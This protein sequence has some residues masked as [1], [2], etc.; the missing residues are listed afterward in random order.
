MTSCPGI[1]LCGAINEGRVPQGKRMQLRVVFDG[2]ASLSGNTGKTSADGIAVDRSRVEDI[3]GGGLSAS[4]WA[5][6]SCATGGAGGRGRGDS[7]GRDT[8]PDASFPPR[9][10]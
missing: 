10:Y 2:S 4:A 1:V 6:A 8:P 9:R 7:T 5:Q 3:R